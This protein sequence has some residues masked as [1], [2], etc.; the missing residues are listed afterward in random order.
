MGA[1]A[2]LDSTVVPV[3]TRFF[4]HNCSCSFEITEIT[5]RIDL[6]C[7][8]C[9]STF[10]EEFVPHQ[11]DAWMPDIISRRPNHGR[12]FSRGLNEEQSRR[13]L[14][15]SI[16][17]RML[18]AQLQEELA[19]L[20][21][22]YSA[23]QIEA[24]G[25]QKVLSETM[26][27]KLRRPCTNVDMICSQPSCPVC[28]EDFVVEIEALQMPCS[29]I[30][31]EVCVMPWLESKKTCP[32]C[33]YEL[34][35]TVST[36]EELERLT[37]MELMAKIC[38]FEAASNTTDSDSSSSNKATSKSKRELAIHLHKL[39]V[40]QDE[41]QK[42]EREAATA[43]AESASSPA[44]RM[45]IF[46]PPYDDYNTSDSNAIEP[47]G[48]RSRLGLS[49]E[50]SERDDGWRALLAGDSSYAGYSRRPLHMMSQLTASSPSV[51]SSSS[52]TAGVMHNVSSSM[53]GNQHN[54]NNPNN[55]LR[56]FYGFVQD[57]QDEDSTTSGAIRGNGA[58]WAYESAMSDEAQLLEQLHRDLAINP[59]YSRDS[60]GGARIVIRTVD[61]DDSDDDDDDSR[62]D[63]DDEDID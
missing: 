14:N 6:C 8:R 34:N 5:R 15:A 3:A 35:D 60:I 37:D 16:M 39:L 41:I 43:I 31:H 30:F 59:H 47:S 61:N 11:N 45:F 1:G 9:Q 18:E 25:K 26:K 23:A 20:Q 50:N 46:D 36:V 27:A 49:T 53:E 7:V 51:I 21:L 13:L 19:Q 12:G 52:A 62:R 57:N 63:S 17:L 33:R 56:G 54:H 4:C 42:K 10:L 40:E 55:S 22:A 48:T 2:S 58:T 44:R 29:H 38:S 24:V 28:S 32:I